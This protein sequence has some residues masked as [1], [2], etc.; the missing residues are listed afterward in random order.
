LGF[1]DAMCYLF[2]A[3]RV[4][5]LVVLT[6][7]ALACS[8]SG[9]SALRSATAGSCQRLCEDEHPDSLYDRNRCLEDCEP[10]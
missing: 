5:L 9:R 4:L 3:M 10:P 1:D 7:V 8:A 2:S 6:M